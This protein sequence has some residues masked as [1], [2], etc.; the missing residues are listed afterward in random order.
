[1]TPVFDLQLIARR[2]TG[3]RLVSILVFC[4]AAGFGA[5]GLTAQDP[6]P[7]DTPPAGTEPAPTQP[8]APAPAGTEKKEEAAP[9]QPTPAPTPVPASTDETK[10]PAEAAPTP[11]PERRQPARE[12]PAPRREEQ[13]AR[14]PAA[15]ATEEAQQPAG[16]PTGGPAPAE[17]PAPAPIPVAQGMA[18][19]LPVFDRELLPEYDKLQQPPRE[20]PH[21]QDDG[22]QAV[23]P[24]PVPVDGAEVA[25]GD[26]QVDEGPGWISRF[27]DS[28]WSDRTVRNGIFVVALILVFIIFRLRNG[29]SRKGYL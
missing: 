22:Q 16:T 4:I 1:M 15:A 18:D 5:T 9:T 13:P 29:R 14:K 7:S 28:I 20:F 26:S 6:A 19:E 21:L 17:A 27:F 12:T 10:Q 11:A 23:D 2:R 8:V 3:V 25:E 24:E